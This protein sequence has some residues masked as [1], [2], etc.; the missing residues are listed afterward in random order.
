M[1]YSLYFRGDDEKQW[2]LLKGSLHENAFSFD[3]DILADGK[4]YFR[5]IASDA[6]VN[7]RPTAR[8]AELISAP[9]L[10]DNTPPVLTTGA[11]RRNG[12]HADVEFDAFDSGSQLRRCE[13]SLDAAGW[14]PEP[15]ADGVIDSRREKFDISLDNLMPGEHLLVI[16]VVDA[17]G[18]TGLAKVVLR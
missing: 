11:V 15:S 6:E 9:V 7:P 5:V 10:I 16:R 4:Y 2:K 12:G 13:Y 14:V 17:A 8:E 3:G 18:N 1:L